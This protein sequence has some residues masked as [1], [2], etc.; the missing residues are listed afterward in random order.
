MKMSKLAVPYLVTGIGCCPPVFG[1]SPGEPPTH[2]VKSRYNPAAPKPLLSHSE[3]NPLS[4]DL[5]FDD[6][7]LKE[8]QF[9]CRQIWGFYF[10]VALNQ[11]RKKIEEIELRQLAQQ[12]SQLPKENQIKFY[13]YQRLLNGG[14]SYHDVNPETYLSQDLQEK[15]DA[16]VTDA[17]VYF[18]PSEIQ[19]IAKYAIQ[20]LRDQ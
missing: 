10:G 1:F 16:K 5:D 15:I 12:F 14:V 7:S 18:K 8:Q 11:D 6:M 3:V 19:K 17:L 9:K 4:L 20:E 2:V 13:V